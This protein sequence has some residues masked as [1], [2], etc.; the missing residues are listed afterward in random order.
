MTTG[1][2]SLVTDDHKA[3][4]YAFGQTRSRQGYDH[5]GDGYT[6]LPELRSQTFGLNSY[7]RLSPYS[8]LSLQ[9]SAIHEYRRGGNQLDQA[10]P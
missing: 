2:V 6:E 10:S 5:D 1:N 7:L 3:G 4:V 9:Y 8:K